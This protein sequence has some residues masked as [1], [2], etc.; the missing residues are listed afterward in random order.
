MDSWAEQPQYTW[1]HPGVQGCTSRELG[2]LLHGPVGCEDISHSTCECIS[3][4]QNPG[5]GIFLTFP[6][7]H[8]KDS[9]FLHQSKWWPVATTIRG[10]SNAFASS[11][12]SEIINRQ[13]EKKAASC[14][15]CRLV[16]I[17]GSFWG[18]TDHLTTYHLLGPPT[19]LPGEELA[20]DDALNLWNPLLKPVKCW[21]WHRRGGTQSP[22]KKQILH[23]SCFIGANDLLTPVGVLSQDQL[24]LRR[25]LSYSVGSNS[26]L[27]GTPLVEKQPVILKP[28]LTKA[29]PMGYY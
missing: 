4:E 14:W 16:W 20:P 25:A 3:V 18:I 8:L 28:L 29:F 12:A 23:S 27:G 7:P 22:R 2:T 13:Q 9:G 10:L 19:Q 5:E 15:M 21:M 24:L 26:A 17:W 1:Q 6:A 11:V